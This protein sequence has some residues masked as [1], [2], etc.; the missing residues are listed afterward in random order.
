MNES[1]Y[2]IVANHEEF[3]WRT[4]NGDVLAIDEISNTHLFNIIQMLKRNW[5]YYF[6]S[7]MSNFPAGLQGDMARYYTEG[8]WQH[9]VNMTLGIRDNVIPWLEEEYSRR[10]EL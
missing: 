10:V 2:D 8:E 9:Q 4:K 1:I 7:A 3:H 5:P 6:E